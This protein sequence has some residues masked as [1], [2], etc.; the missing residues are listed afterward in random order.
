[1]EFSFTK[2]NHIGIYELKGKLMGETDGMPIIDSF[3]QNQEEGIDMFIMDLSELKLMN[4]VGIGVLIRLLT[5]ARKKGGELVLS[6]PSEYIRNL[7]VMTKLN[8]IFTIFGDK[9]EALDSF[10]D[11]AS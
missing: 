5:K 7:L 6:A 2:E 1:M 4:S 9:A 11:K 3:V 8:T 10:A